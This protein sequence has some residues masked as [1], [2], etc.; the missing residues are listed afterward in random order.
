MQPALLDA[1]APDLAVL[2]GAGSRCSPDAEL[3]GAE[4]RPEV[5]AG[6][7]HS[8]ADLKGAL[9]LFSYPPLLDRMMILQRS[10]AATGCCR[11]P[12]PRPQASLGKPDRESQGA[13][14]AQFIARVMRVGR[15]RKTC[16]PIRPLCT[17]P[18]CSEKIA[19]GCG[20]HE[21]LGWG[22]P[23]PLETKEARTSTAEEGGDPGAGAGGMR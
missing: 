8:F 6:G 1:P 19:R 22:A 21:G 17:W 12:R 11:Q 5:C 2:A 4:A 20:V 3:C 7:G 15:S 18:G 9:I 13:P 14:E 10:D 16:W 23:L